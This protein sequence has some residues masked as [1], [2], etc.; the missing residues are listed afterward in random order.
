MMTYED[1]LV[2]PQAS[3]YICD[4]AKKKGY[5]KP[6]GCAI[7]SK[8]IKPNSMCSIVFFLV[9]RKFES[10]TTAELVLTPCQPSSQVR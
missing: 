3:N 5:F 8:S 9:N 4:K 7:F 6:A 10:L 2:N 1:S